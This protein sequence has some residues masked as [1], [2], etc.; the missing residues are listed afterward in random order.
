MLEMQLVLA[1][2]VWAFDLEAV[3]GSSFDLESLKTFVVVQKQPFMVRLKARVI[4]S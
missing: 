1:R 3:Q 2:L 4:K